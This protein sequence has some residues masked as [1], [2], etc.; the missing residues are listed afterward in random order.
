MVDIILV[1]LLG[2]AFLLGF[3]QGVIRGLLS[4]AAWFVA[5]I[6]AA[7]LSEPVGDWLNGQWV[8]FTPEYNRMLAF[9]I[10]A[11]L[12]FAIAEVLIQFGTRNTAT[13]S[14]YPL[15]DDVLGGVLGMVLGVLLLAGMIVV[16]DSFYASTDAVATAQDAASTAQLYR[17]VQ[18]SAIS[19]L[20]RDSIVPGLGVVLELLIPGHV[21]AVMR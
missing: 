15:L 4:I 16:L 20:V 13:L 6:V 2:G 18:D 5:F 8:Q 3:F 14:R 19:Q 7:N 17:T 21:R 10:V 12:L 1:L 9:G 11:L